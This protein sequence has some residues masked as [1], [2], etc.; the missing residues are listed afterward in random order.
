M[1]IKNLYEPANE[2]IFDLIWR[3]K[4]DQ[5]SKKNPPQTFS[6]FSAG[7]DVNKVYKCGDFH[8]KTPTD[9]VKGFDIRR[10]FNVRSAIWLATLSYGEYLIFGRIS[11]QFLI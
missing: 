3:S 1:I 9:F 11:G 7:Q 6:G 10:S 4:T 5:F 2:S 8:K